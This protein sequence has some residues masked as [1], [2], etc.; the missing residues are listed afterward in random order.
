MMATCMPYVGQCVIFGVDT[1]KPPLF[2]AQYLKSCFDAICLSSHRK[3]LLFKEV[4]NCVVGNEF[5]KS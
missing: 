1:D 2:T 3:P 5:L 4:A